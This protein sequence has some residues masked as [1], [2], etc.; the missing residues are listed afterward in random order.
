MAGF[1]GA[2]GVPLKQMQDAIAQSTAIATYTSDERTIDAA[3]RGVF[4]FN[5]AKSGYTP[6]GI[7]DLA[8]SNNYMYVGSFSIAGSTA[9]VVI[10]NRTNA[11]AT[12]QTVTIRVLY[13][14]A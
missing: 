13:A 6:I 10:H 5:V 11:T 1:S 2:T 3:N 7:V 9:T 8:L 14:K 4:T 12:P